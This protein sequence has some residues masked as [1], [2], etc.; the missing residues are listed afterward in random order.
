MGT[1][2]HSGG[3]A[4]KI[5]KITQNY[6]NVV[7]KGCVNHDEISEEG[8]KERNRALNYSLRMIRATLD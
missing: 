2:I 6:L 8:T 5:Q 3:K 4:G 1:D 7:W